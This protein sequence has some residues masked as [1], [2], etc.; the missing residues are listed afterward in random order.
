LPAAQLAGRLQ[1]TLIGHGI[2]DRDVRD[3][4]REAGQYGFDA[5]VVPPLWVT[6]AREELR[7]S[8]IRLG[9]IV[10]FPD[11]TGT[12][13][14][15][16]G[17]V[18]SLVDEGVDELDCTVPIGLLLSGRIREFIADLT[19]VVAAAS[20]VGV[21]FMLELPLLSDRLRL[22]AVHAAVDAGAAFLTPA[23][24]GRVG[25]ADPAT[26]AF[27][28]HQAPAS[29]G[30]KASGGV[31]TIEQV[32]SLLVAGADLIGTSSGL[33]IVNGTRSSGSLYSY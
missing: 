6:V 7:G 9:S 29:V 28:R 20:P 27:L 23:S 13:A 3:H 25:I 14:G 21:K 16:A 1:H 32:R 24:S 10:D 33:S 4:V 11:G 22:H 15:R 17:Q 8:D 30:V 31:Q 2:T 19:A 18:R 12:T 26:I 5:V